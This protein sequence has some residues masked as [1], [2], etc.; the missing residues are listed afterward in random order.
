MATSKC[1]IGFQFENYAN[2]NAPLGR[3]GLVSE[4]SSVLKFLASN[5]ASYVNGAIWVVDGG[6]SLYTNPLI[7]M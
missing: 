4:M 6:V 2:D 1:S 7:L 5:E 3:I